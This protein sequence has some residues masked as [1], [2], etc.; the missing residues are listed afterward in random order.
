MRFFACQIHF[1]KN[2]SKCFWLVVEPTH[3][4]NMLVNWLIFPNFRGEK[5]PKK[6]LENHHP[7]TIFF[8][9]HCSS[10][11]VFH[12]P[13]PTIHFRGGGSIY[14]K[15]TSQFFL[16]P[17]DSA[18]LILKKN[19]APKLAIPVGNPFIAAKNPRSWRQHSTD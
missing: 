16:L 13:I 9:K 19:P 17:N 8:Y 11:G 10:W 2:K 4:K 18:A 14:W 15:T 1:Q 12:L 5:N 7:V 3:L 6:I